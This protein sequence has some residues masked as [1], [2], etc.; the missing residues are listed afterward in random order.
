MFADGSD[1]EGRIMQQQQQQ[2]GRV[3]GEGGGS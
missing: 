2:V 1:G 3:G